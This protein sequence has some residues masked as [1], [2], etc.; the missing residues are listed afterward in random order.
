MTFGALQ[1]LTRHDAP[2]V[3][4][5]LASAIVYH[6]RKPTGRKYPYKSYGYYHTVANRLRGDST[7]NLKLTI[8]AAI[9]LSI[10]PTMAMPISR[11][12]YAACTVCR[13]VTP[14][15]GSLIFW[16]V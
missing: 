1:S 14:T 3:F 16:G 11:T 13:Q 15:G 10:R 9:S 6:T 2:A 5:S 12:S 4:G 7:F 8:P